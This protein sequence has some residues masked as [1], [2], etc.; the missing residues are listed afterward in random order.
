[1][2]LPRSLSTP[3]VLTQLSGGGKVLRRP[4]RPGSLKISQQANLNRLSSMSSMD[5]NN[6][7]E[8]VV[9]MENICRHLVNKNYSLVVMSALQ[10][11]CNSL[12]LYGVQLDTL[13]KD[14]LDKLMVVF[15][16]T[17]RDEDLDLVSRVQILHII[18]LRAAGWNTNDNMVAYYKQKLSHL[19][20]MRDL[21]QVRQDISPQLNV[22]HISPHCQVQTA[23][24]SLNANAPD[25]TPYSGSLSSL[26]LP[27][28]VVG[29]SGKFSQPTRIPGKNY[30][31]V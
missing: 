12:H 14:Q 25:F 24:V 22:F 6:L 26:L 18:E 8:M 20:K 5:M 11:L 3:G 9:T 31:K 15:R 27:G 1:M 2:S 4:N 10:G 23:P 30:F 7:E 13:Y 28:E 19:D 16:T 21:P 29:S 17:C